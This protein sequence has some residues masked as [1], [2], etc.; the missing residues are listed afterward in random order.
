MDPRSPIARQGGFGQLRSWGPRQEKTRKDKK[1]QENYLGSYKKGHPV[2]VSL[3]YCAWCGSLLSVASFT[4]G[5]SPQFVS[6]FILHPTF[7][8]QVGFFLRFSSTNIL[9]GISESESSFQNLGKGFF[10]SILKTILGRFYLQR[11]SMIEIP[12]VL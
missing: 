5:A 2:R 11:I 7:C 10:S 3:F 1:R 4:E 9:L 6:S 12:S 8:L